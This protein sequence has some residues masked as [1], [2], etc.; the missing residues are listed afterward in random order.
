MSEEEKAERDAK[1]AER[2][3]EI[4]KLKIDAELI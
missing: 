2:P 4:L 3:A 1:K